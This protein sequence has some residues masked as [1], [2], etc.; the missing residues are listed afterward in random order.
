MVGQFDGCP[1]LSALGH[2]QK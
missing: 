2:K 1:F